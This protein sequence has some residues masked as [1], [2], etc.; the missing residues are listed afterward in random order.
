MVFEEDFFK[1][2]T[3]QLYRHIRW[4]KAGYLQN[5]DQPEGKPE[6]NARFAATLMAIKGF[7]GFCID[8]LLP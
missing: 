4:A 2:D 1:R 6:K 7:Y 8:S 5:F 3:A